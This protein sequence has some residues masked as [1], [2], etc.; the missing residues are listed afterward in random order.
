MTVVCVYHCCVM[1]ME[2][3]RV[4]SWDEWGQ[5]TVYCCFVEQEVV[6][7]VCDTLSYSSPLLS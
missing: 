1:H 5:L 7:C 2:D 3:S 4:A 6:S